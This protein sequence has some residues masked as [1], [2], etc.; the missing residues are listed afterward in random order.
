LYSLSS[1]VALRV[2]DPEVCASHAAKECI[3]GSASVYGCPWETYPGSLTRNV[4]CGLCFECLRACPKGNVALYARPFGQDLTPRAGTSHAGWPRLDEGFGA[5]VMLALAGIYSAVFLGPWGGLKQ[6]ALLATPDDSVRHA[7]LVIGGAAAVAPAAWL[8]VAA[9]ARLL[10]GR[11]DVRLRAVWA[12][13]ATAF[14]PLGLLAW[15][16]FTASFVLGA[17]GYVA[18][19]ATDPLG[20]GWDLLALGAIHLP[21]PAGLLLWLQVAAW[22]VGLVW[23]V[24]VGRRASGVLFGEGRPALLSGVVV[25]AGL[26]VATGGLVW[27]GLG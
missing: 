7:F 23:A 14:V 2:K 20:W 27:L 11:P 18:S 17:G 8:G 15:V 5:I 16:A 10:A 12:G 26:S 19:V 3:R 22:A 4:D 24:R 21:A 13:T 9:L 1:P 6:E 25:A